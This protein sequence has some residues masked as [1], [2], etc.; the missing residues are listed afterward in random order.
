MLKK[1]LA[2]DSDQER[3]DLVAADYNSR[4]DLFKEIGAFELLEALVP[5]ESDALSVLQRLEPLVIEA[6]AQVH[7]AFALALTKRVLP[8]AYRMFPRLADFAIA[9]MMDQRMKRAT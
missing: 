6:T 1:L 7:D 5:P 8:D 9:R 4:T 2:L 3:I